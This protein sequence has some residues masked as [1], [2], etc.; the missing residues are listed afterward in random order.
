MAFFSYTKPLIEIANG[1]MWAM[2]REA[3]LLWLRSKAGT[4]I[5]QTLMSDGKFG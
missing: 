5:V 2:G 3:H 4:G 1:I